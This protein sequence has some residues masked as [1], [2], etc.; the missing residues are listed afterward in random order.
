MYTWCTL[1]TTGSFGLCD[2]FPLTDFQNSVVDIF[3]TCS[4]QLF[5]CS[6]CSEV[7]ASLYFSR[8]VWC[9]RFSLI[10]DT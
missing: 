8:A 10:L 3:F 6:I 9:G 5:I 4:H 7:F 2:L 1:M